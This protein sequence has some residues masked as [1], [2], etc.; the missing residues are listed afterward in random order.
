MYFFGKDPVEALAF[1]ARFL[2]IVESADHTILRLLRYLPSS[3][4]RPPTCDRSCT[5]VAQALEITLHRKDL[6]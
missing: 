1:L 4:P 5:Q 2:I 3:A 6:R